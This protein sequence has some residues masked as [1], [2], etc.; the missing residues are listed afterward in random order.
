M[1]ITLRKGKENVAIYINDREF[2]NF[3]HRYVATP[4][5][6]DE[7]GWTE[8]QTDPIELKHKDINLGIDYEMLDDSNNII[9]IQERFRESSYN[10]YND[11]TIR[12]QR[13]HN[14]DPSRKQSEYFK[15]KADYFVYGITNG[16]KSNYEE[17]V[18][19]FLKIAIVDI[20]VLKDKFDNGFIKIGNSKKSF[21]KDG[22]LYAGYNVNCD[23]S[24][25]FIVLDL[26]HLHQLFD[27]DG[28]VYFQEGFY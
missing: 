28:I 14:P 6:Y 21:I 22:I 23:Y 20:N 25:E 7:I 3:V 8:Y 2:T 15:I 17:M 12:Y 18:N 24:S 27:N 13:V 9:R 5:I 10:N 16:P 1:V 4:L 26:I 19:G 11:I